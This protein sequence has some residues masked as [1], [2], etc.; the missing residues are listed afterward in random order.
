MRMRH[1]G[2]SRTDIDR[3]V[4]LHDYATPEGGAGVLALAS[5]EHY[6]AAGYKVTYIAGSGSSP[7]IER[8]GVD[9]VGLG[10][11][12]LLKTGAM[13]ALRQGYDNADAARL[14][15]DW[16][17]A[18]DTPGTVYHLHN[19]SQILSPSIFAPL[20]RVAGRTV[21]TCHDFFNICPNGGYVH[22]G[23]S[24]I[25]DKKA[26]SLGCTLSQCDRRSTLH[27]YWRLARLHHHH[28]LAQPSTSDF[29]WVFLHEGMQKTSTS[30]GFDAP[31]MR[32][33]RNPV[34]AWSETRVEAERNADFLFV[35]RIGKDKGVD[36]ALDATKR[37]GI[38]LTVIGDGDLREE[39]EAFYTHARFV[40][41]KTPDEITRY[42]RKAR[43]LLMP[44]RMLEPF[45]LVALEAAMS[46]V[47]VILTNKSYLAAELERIG[48]GLG[49][50]VRNVENFSG[51]IRL[52]AG[53]D[54]L[55]EVMSRAGFE[56]AGKLCN[57]YESWTGAF[58]DLFR[59]KLGL[60]RLQEAAE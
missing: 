45:G 12:G 59:E 6:K 26:F 40:G 57:T 11:E 33:I 46:G 38:G 41:R 43:A 21:V 55:A 34:K 14:V 51:A 24:E 25:C 29:T 1:N 10:L 37:A 36:L 42:A 47:P 23:K 2:M 27:K 28:K 20:Q 53:N 35:G 49:A 16:I 58:L 22:F 7:D 56:H 32:T 52:L 13:T 50:S 31:D 17:T 60:K 8:L 5:A 18:N 48:A 39:A 30:I 44:S 9:F 3:I 4:V 15:D 54:Q 19:W